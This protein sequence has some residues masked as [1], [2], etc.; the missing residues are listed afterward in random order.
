[1]AN[2]RM[3]EMTVMKRKGMLIC[4]TTP[5]LVCGG[6]SWLER[7]DRTGVLF[8]RFGGL[9]GSVNVVAKWSG[10][11]GH[12]TRGSPGVLVAATGVASSM[13]FL[14]PNASRRESSVS[15]T[16]STGSWGS[17]W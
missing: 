13:S 9:V 7:F 2:A 5:G 8:L 10:S 15:L 17:V 14:K 3:K 16:D 6:E 11:S 1:V 12:W 4:R